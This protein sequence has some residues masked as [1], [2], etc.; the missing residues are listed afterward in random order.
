MLQMTASPIPLFVE[1]AQGGCKTLRSSEGPR[2]RGHAASRER[3]E[4][5]RLIMIVEFRQNRENECSSQLRSR[6][7]HNAT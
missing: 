3:N 6:V 5:D 4:A 7:L 2:M 1:V